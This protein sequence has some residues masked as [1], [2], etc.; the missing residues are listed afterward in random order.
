MGLQT[1]KKLFEEWK[2]Q[3]RGIVS[4]KWNSQEIISFALFCLGKHALSE[5]PTQISDEEIEKE[6]TRN[7]GEKETHN[8]ISARF[9]IKWAI[10]KA[11]DKEA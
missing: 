7:Y 11:R 8:K 3:H 2:E 4:G 5:A 9:G 10:S 1:T 6:L